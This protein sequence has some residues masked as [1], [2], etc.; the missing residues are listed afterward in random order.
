MRFK[1]IA[2]RVLPSSVFKLLWGDRKKFGPLPDPADS[3][4]RRWQEQVSLMVA[5]DRLRGFTEIVHRLGYRILRRVN[6]EGRRVLEIGPGFI[7][8]LPFF[9]SRPDLYIICDISREF[10][11]KA[12]NM[13]SENGFPVQ[14]FLLNQSETF[15]LPLDDESVDFVVSFYSLE[16]FHPLDEYLSEIRRVLKVGGKIV[17]AVPIEG[18]LAWG[19]GRFLTTRRS[20]RKNYGIDYD[21][22]IC[23]EHC[24]FADFIFDRLERNFTPIQRK[25]H[26]FPFLPMD[27][28]LIGS[29]IY[30][31]MSE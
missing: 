19:L 13:L 12:E 4:W 6:V 22:I 24:N 26:P 9:Q 2:N 25:L 28:N 21:K 11:E 29:F 1:L 14:A 20:A 27:L 17:G 10:L 15:G 23:W 31:K 18:G 3:E 7:P 16:H 30:Q 5:R 8:Y